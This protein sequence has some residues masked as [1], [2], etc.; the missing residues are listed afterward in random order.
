MT[1][2]QEP[3]IDAPAVRLR[4]DKSNWGVIIFFAA[5]GIVPFLLF[6]AGS[7]PKAMADLVLMGVSEGM[8]LIP[9]V[10]FGIWQAK[11]VVVADEYGLKWRG[12]G[13]WHTAKWSDVT[14]YYER[15]LPKG[16]I[17]FTIETTSG[18]LNIS[19]NFWSISPELKNIITQK[20]NKARATRWEIMG[21][22]SEVDWPRIFS[23]NT[24]DNRTNGIILY[25]SVFVLIG[26]LLWVA[27]PGVIKA[28]HAQGGS[29]ALATLGIFCFGML[30]TPLLVIVVFRMR[31]SAMRGRSG[32]QITLRQ[33]GVLYKD[34][35]RRVEAHWGDITDL[36]LTRGKE[37][38]Y[39]Y[40]V[41]TTQ[42]TF[43]FSPTIKDCAILSRAL[44]AHATALPDAK[45]R[46]TETDTLGGIS[47]RWTSGCEGV[48]KRVYHY[49]TRTIRAVLWFPTVMALGVAVMHWGLP[50]LGL[51]APGTTGLFLY[52]ALAA[53]G[54]WRYLCGAIETDTE[55]IT[56]RT[57]FGTRHLAWEDVTDI[58]TSGDA[59]FLFGVVNGKKA[60]LQFWMGITDVADLKS[61]IARQAVNSAHRDWGKIVLDE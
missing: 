3:A 19:P 2:T 26:L 13:R 1:I 8:F 24:K 39:R 53:W 11:A 12:M 17:G 10:L 52:G 60:H 48:G 20:A 22:H 32:Q 61:E 14:D 43:D 58:R 50:L 42:G 57:L 23:Y 31:R 25:A 59:P 6:L 7:Q 45:W 41:V 51:A 9:A 47:S 36:F 55:G 56:Q 34:E 21:L 33:E 38:T 35:A 5:I 16:K 4:P 18:K 28:F 40:V 29:W 49:R 27:V 15:V 30:P 44:T 54:W 37:M 46:N